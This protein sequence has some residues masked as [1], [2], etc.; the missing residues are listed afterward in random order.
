MKKITFVIPLYNEAPTLAALA[1]GIK[2]HVGDHPFRILFVDDGSTDDSWEVMQGLRQEDPR[3]ELLRLRRNCGKTAALEAAF[4]V[5]KGD[6]LITMDADL[7]DDPAEIP[8][9]LAKLEEGYDLVC[10][11]K[12]KR[13]DPWLKTFPSRFYNKR[14]SRRFNLP[15]HDINTG[16]KAMRMEVAKS[17]RLWSDMHRLIP[18][19]AHHL[20]YK[21]TEIPVRH[22]P[23]KFGK[24]KYGFSRIQKGLA[25][26]ESATNIVKNQ[27]APVRKFHD[28]YHSGILFLILFL[29][30]VSAVAFQFNVSLTTVKVLLFVLLAYTLAFYMALFLHLSKMNELVLYR[31][32]PPDP[33]RFVAVY[34]ET[35]WEE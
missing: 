28:Y 15:L 30:V 32:P 22:H 34:E 1:Q 18:V 6:I 24:S 16:F 3:I 21:V 25:D 10:G 29:F 31:L 2:E 19:F 13:H 23:R 20:G 17:L 33:K 4:A 7:Q 35:P 5:A 12:K 14:I 27:D 11:W 9:M 26:I 8:R